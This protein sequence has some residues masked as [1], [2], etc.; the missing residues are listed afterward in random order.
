MQKYDSNSLYRNPLII[1][2]CIKMT[3]E[4]KVASYDVRHFKALFLYFQLN[5]AHL[6]M[7]HELRTTQGPMC[8]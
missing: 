7:T 8:T 6:C 4:A 5:W 3:N 2:I 1:V